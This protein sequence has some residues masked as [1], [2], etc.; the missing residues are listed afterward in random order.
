M[1]K[2]KN[3]KINKN[4]IIIIIVGVIALILLV[5]FIQ[6][7]KLSD[8]KQQITPTSILSTK[9]TP[10][11]VNY[12]SDNLKISIT[13]PSSYK[14]NE[15][16]NDII[17]TNN[18]GKINVLR[19]STNN[20]TIEGY[21]FE[22]SDRGK[23]EIINKQKIKINGLES[24]SCI[25]K[26]PISGSPDSRAYYFYPEPWTVFVISTNVPELFGDLDQ[27]ARSFRYEP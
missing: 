5:I 6:N 16:Y 17:L 4:I 27:I 12:K 26:H 25:I 20:D 9:P 15:S 3:K 1:A 24:I 19:N 10:E 8:I 14:I 22:I 2:K 18:I 11:I 7:Q 21:L 23:I 13:A